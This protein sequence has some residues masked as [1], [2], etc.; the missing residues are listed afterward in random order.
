MSLL[1]SIVQNMQAERP[2][3]VK[4]ARIVQKFSLPAPP[5][6]VTRRRSTCRWIVRVNGEVR[7][8]GWRAAGWR[9]R[10]RDLRALLLASGVAPTVVI[11]R[12]S[13]RYKTFPK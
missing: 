5:D 12:Y 9:Q 6:P 3:P 8:T 4:P 1:D 11:N 10:V 7:E 2:V 13:G